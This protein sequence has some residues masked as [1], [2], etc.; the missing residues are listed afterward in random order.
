[1]DRYLEA[2]DAAEQARIQGDNAKAVLLYEEA[3]SLA[4][5]SSAADPV[6]LHH[7]WGVALTSLGRLE[8]AR[9]HLIRA[10]EHSSST[11]NSVTWAAI[12]RDLALLY[13]ADGQPS[14]AISEI[15]KSLTYLSTEDPS[16]IAERGASIGIK[17]RIL[18]VQNRIYT[19]REYFG[20]ADALL[21]R[22]DNRHYELY[23]LMHFLEALVEYRLPFFEDNWAEIQFARDQVSRLRALAMNYGGL[24]RQ[25]RAAHIISSVLAER[26]S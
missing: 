8:D 3:A 11:H 14:R 2:F 6:T 12:S 7:M 17:A 22:S 21:Q 9:Q 26:E 5:Y 4:E 20:T 23:N 10:E 18:L 13:L 16:R 1:M 25:Q 24:P 15:D 19:A